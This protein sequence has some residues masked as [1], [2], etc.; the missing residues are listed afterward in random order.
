MRRTTLIIFSI[1]CLISGR[2]YAKNVEAISLDVY[3]T[4]NPHSTYRVQL[5]ESKE[6]VKGVYLPAGTIIIGEVINIKPPQ[7]GKRDAYFE[8]IP[9]KIIYANEVT[10]IDNPTYYAKVIDYKPVKPKEVA[11]KAARTGAGLLVKGLTQGISFVQGAT[12]ADEGTRIKSG[13]QRMYED[14]PLS[15]IE[16]GDEMLLQVGDMLTLKFKKMK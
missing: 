10:K 15:Y 5:T 11:V 2:A 12:E 9:N 16:A 13:F 6:V 4:L 3:S 8:I 1:F 7:R 14:S